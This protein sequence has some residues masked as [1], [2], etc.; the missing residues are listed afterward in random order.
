MNWR[1]LPEHEYFLYARSYHV[2]AKKLAR[3]L[4]LDHGPLADLDLCPVLS[5]YRHS[6]E[7][8]LKVIVLGEGGNFLPSRPDVLS[9]H[10]TRSLSWLAQFV[11]QIVSALKWEEEFN[12]EGIDSLADF[13]VVIEEANG[14]DPAYHS[15]R[16]PAG[17]DR[18]ERLRST[19]LAYLRRLDAMVELLERTAD[20]LAAE[21]DLRTHP[22]SNPE[23]PD[24][25]PSI[26]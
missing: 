11:I 9:V 14:L 25:M 18:P 15:F 26:Q 8:H 2:A 22:A 20:G 19:V 23:W 21:W 24:G 16:C 17:P 1:N 4:D 7:L 13:K 12:A 6:I 5:M 10:K 3:T